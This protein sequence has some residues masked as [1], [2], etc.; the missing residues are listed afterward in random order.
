[1]FAK[2]RCYIRHVATV[3][4]LEAFSR[5]SS[6][7]R[8]KAI[9]KGLPIKALRDLIADPV[10]SLAAVSRVVGPRRTLDRRL[11]ENT[12]LSPEE[13]DRFARFLNIL[14]ITTQM[15]GSRAEAMRWLDSPKR[16]FEGER[17]LDL[18]KTDAGAR[19]IEELILQARHGFLA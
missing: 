8:V 13:S 7:K 19:M 16:R 4:S 10:I 18:L 2:W 5:Q 3:F 17:P 6:L 1:M 15:F 9:E 12:P 11:K 14:Q